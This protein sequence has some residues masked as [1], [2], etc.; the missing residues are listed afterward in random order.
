[1]C[2]VDHRSNYFSYRFLPTGNPHREFEI[3]FLVHVSNN[4]VPKDGGF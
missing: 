3:G 4:F 2:V 1:M